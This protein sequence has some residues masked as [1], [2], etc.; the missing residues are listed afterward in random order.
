MGKIGFIGL[1]AMGSGMALNLTKKAKEVMVFDIRPEAC[2]A[3]VQA[4]AIR[5]ARVEDMAVC[6]PILIMVNTGDQ[7]N[8]VLKLLSTSKDL[9]KGLTVAVMSTVSRKQIREIAKRYNENGI[10]V[11][12]AP[13]S[14]GPLLAQLGSLSVMMGGTGKQVEKLRPALEAVSRVIFHVGEVGQGEAMK[15]V[16]NVL[17]ICNMVLTPAALRVGMGAGLDLK[18]MVEVINASAGKNL[19]TEAWE[20]ALMT[21]ET[22]YG[23]PSARTT[24]LK[25]NEKDIRAYLDLV[26][27]VDTKSAAG[28]AVLAMTLSDDQVDRTWLDAFTAAMAK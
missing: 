3:C 9:K 23:T 13:V 26:K 10:E 11:V 4:G 15:L 27:E 17:T 20:G 25:I 14:G 1:G 8:D 21:F 2:D 22:L 28:E 18:K 16:N 24:Q 19:M 6:D 12:D 7:V 5:A